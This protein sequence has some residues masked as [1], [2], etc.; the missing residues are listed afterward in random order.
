MKMSE[1]LYVDEFGR[2]VLDVTDYYDEAVTAERCEANV[3]VL[4]EGDDDDWSVTYL[5]LVSPT[6]DLSRVLGDEY[7]RFPKNEIDPEKPLF[8]QLS[9]IG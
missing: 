5:W 4:R 9:L 2:D 1:V 8:Q 3:L 6:A 7:S